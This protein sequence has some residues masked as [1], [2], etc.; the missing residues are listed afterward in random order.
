MK[1]HLKKWKKC[2]NKRNKMRRIES[3]SRGVKSTLRDNEE[4]SRTS[5]CKK[6]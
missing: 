2:K 3:E 1:K 6:S 5:R 4:I